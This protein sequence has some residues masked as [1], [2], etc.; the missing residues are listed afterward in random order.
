ML[1]LLISVIV[2][3]ALL[4]ACSDS[5]TTS[6]DTIS[7]ETV[8]RSTVAP[9]LP[10]ADIVLESVTFGGDVTTFKPVGWEFDGEIGLA[11]PA[12]IAGVP[13]SWAI[14]DDGLGNCEPRSS[15]EWR[16]AATA[17]YGLVS[18]ESVEVV[19][20]VSG[21]ASYLV[22]THSTEGWGELVYWRWVD[23]APQLI[24][25]MANG[26]DDVIDQLFAALEFACENT[27]A[28]LDGD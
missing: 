26:P 27:R 4:S 10:A 28:A 5:E 6:A 8:V 12:E 20:E 14:V 2:S 22:E 23:G 25:C 1:R 7:E 24:R 13:F 11:F 16:A 15:S 21:D 17:S 9:S 18:P 3:V 19:R